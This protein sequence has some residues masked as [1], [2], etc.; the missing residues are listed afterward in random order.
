MFRLIPD[1][2]FEVR[3]IV[4]DGWPHRTRVMTLAD[5]SG[6]VNGEPYRNEMMQAIEIHWGRVTSIETLE[7]TV[8]LSRALQ[9]LEEAG[10]AEAGAAPHVARPTRRRHPG[11]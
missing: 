7:D 5:L 3:Q 8:V 11:G 9:R 4:V 10:M 1:L 2:H 6:T